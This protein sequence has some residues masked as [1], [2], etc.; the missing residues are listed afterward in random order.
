MLTVFQPLSQSIR[1]DILLTR[2]DTRTLAKEWIEAHIPTGN[3][4]AVDWPVLSPPLYGTWSLVPYSDKQ[5]DITVIGERGLPRHPIAWYREHEFDYLIASSFVYNIRWISKELDAERQAYYVA[6]EQEHE[7][8]QVFNPY[9]SDAELPFIYN[10]M[11]G[12]AINLW[13]RQRPGPT[14]KVYKIQ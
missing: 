12:P 3:K 1:H 5:Y 9:A 13:Q 10:E 4:I 6:L 2:R 8:I 7:L 14:I 11:Y